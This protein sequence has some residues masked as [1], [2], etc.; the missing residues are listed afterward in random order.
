[1][2]KKE[3]LDLIRKISGRLHTAL[4]HITWSN[5]YDN[6]L[7][8]N[9][10]DEKNHLKY[11]PESCRH[12]LTALEGGTFFAVKHII[13]FFHNKN[14]DIFIPDFKFSVYIPQ[15]KDYLSV[16]KVIFSAYAIVENY[17]EQI[18]EAL[19]D[20]DYSEILKMDYVELVQTDKKGVK[21]AEYIC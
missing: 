16:K 15:V 7:K 14:H 11:K 6:Y 18:K 19:K 20:L 13:D 21:Y 10:Q 3:Q 5:I 4:D 2:T 1:M 12:G 8:E 9:I 17:N